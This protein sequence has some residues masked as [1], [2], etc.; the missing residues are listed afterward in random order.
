MAC[1]LFGYQEDE[2]IGKMLKDRVRLKPKD[3]ATILESH[4]ESTG[5]VVNLAGKVVSMQTN[6][7]SKLV[8]SLQYLLTRSPPVDTFGHIYRRPLLLVK[9]YTV[10][11]R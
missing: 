11:P 8:R 2:L 5:E 10:E 4:L 6:M 7:R 9:G 3:Q 1:E